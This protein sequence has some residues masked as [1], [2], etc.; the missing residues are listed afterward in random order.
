MFVPAVIL[1][2]STGGVEENTGRQNKSVRQKGN[3]LTIGI[4]T[5]N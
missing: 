2:G 5:A 1:T 3:I 4:L